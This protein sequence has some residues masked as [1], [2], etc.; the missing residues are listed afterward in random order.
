MKEIASQY[1]KGRQWDQVANNQR[2]E[3]FVQPTLISQKSIGLIARKR[4]IAPDEGQ[5]LR[6]GDSNF[7]RQAQPNPSSHRKRR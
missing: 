1:R 3:V 5:E 7:E 2:D 4:R 6:I